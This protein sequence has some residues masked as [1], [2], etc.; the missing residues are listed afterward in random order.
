[1]G[2]VPIF[3]GLLALAALAFLAVLAADRGAADLA[4]F[5]ARH[6]VDRAGFPGEAAIQR[7]QRGLQQ[8]LR[9][10]GANPDHREYL[11]RLY[12]SRARHRE[13]L[14]SFRASAKARPGSPHAWADIARLKLRLG[15]L[16]GELDNAIKNAARLGPWEPDVQLAIAAVAIEADR[17]L[18]P[19]A[20]RAALAVMSNALKRQE[21]AVV[22]LAFRRGR[23]DLLCSIP[24][25]AAYPAARRCI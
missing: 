16:D 24:G 9:L 11:A 19:D 13:A 22:E 7:A 6:G 14:E 3:L 1:M 10:D 23:L 8:A 21:R 17:R 25:I 2:S 12:E 5:G 4:A 15:E 20:R 18:T